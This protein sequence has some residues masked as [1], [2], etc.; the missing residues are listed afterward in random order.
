MAIPWYSSEFPRPASDPA[1]NFLSTDNVTHEKG[2]DNNLMSINNNYLSLNPVR[3]MIIKSTNLFKLPEPDVDKIS[4]VTCK[5]DKN[6]ELPDRSND[7]GGHDLYHTGLINKAFLPMR[8]ALIAVGRWPVPMTLTRAASR[9]KK[10]TKLVHSTSSDN[11]DAE[12]VIRDP[13][14]ATHVKNYNDTLKSPLWVYFG[15]T[16]FFIFFALVMSTIGFLDFYL[17]WKLLPGNHWDKLD[18]RMFSDNLVVFL[19][20]WGCLVHSAV[21]S[22]SLLINRRKVV[23]IMNFWNVAADELLLDE[24]KTHRRFLIASNLF[25]I[26]F[27]VLL[28]FS[29]SAFNLRLIS[30]GAL[31]FG[32][33]TIRSLLQEDEAEKVEQWR[34]QIF[35]IVTIIYAIYA[36][37]AFLILFCFKSRVLRSLFRVWNSRLICFLRRPDVG[38]NG[39]Q[40]FDKF[41]MKFKLVGILRIVYFL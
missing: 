28:Y 1:V 40:C 35:G 17:E 36:S 7:Y 13:L 29:F 34:M 38:L 8:L 33:L 32:N 6:P 37:R 4:P 23:K 10:Q 22:L 3:Q 41:V 11:M 30:D 21:S 9:F 26:M 2:K 20:V 14:L 25:F 5:D 27:L 18:K 16:S 39:M 12:S 31:L 19:L 24:V 15:L